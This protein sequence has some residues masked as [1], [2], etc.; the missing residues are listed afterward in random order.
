MG[1]AKDDP[2]WRA[3]P[4]KIVFATTGGADLAHAHIAVAKGGQTLVET[5]CD[6]PWV[7][8]KLPPGHYTVT[9]T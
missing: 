9:A 6:A 3:Y 8:L 4:V 7:L 1:S 5:D 2:A